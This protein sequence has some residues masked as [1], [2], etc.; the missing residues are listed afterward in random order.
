LSRDEWLDLIL[1]SVGIEPLPLSHR[2]KMLYLARL[3]PLVESNW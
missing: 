2:L 3:I 1:R